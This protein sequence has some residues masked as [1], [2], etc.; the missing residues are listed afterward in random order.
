MLVVAAALARLRWRLLGVAPLVRWN[1]VPI[2][3][4]A[5]VAD[6]LARA[7][8]DRLGAKPELVGS[9]WLTR[10]VSNPVLGVAH[11][12]A[13]CNLAAEVTVEALSV[14][15][16]FASRLVRQSLVEYGVRWHDLGLSCLALV[17]TGRVATPNI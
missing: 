16:E 17:H 5:I 9:D 3:L 12:D 6:S 15:V 8:L 13:G 7:A 11:K 1:G 2:V 14:H 4:L 10:D